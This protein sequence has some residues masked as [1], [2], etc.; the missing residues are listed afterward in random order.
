MQ[1][2]ITCFA[3]LSTTVA[4]LSNGSVI[5]W[6]SNQAGQLGV[7]DDA[8]YMQVARQSPP[9]GSMPQPKLFQLFLAVLT[10]EM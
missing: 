3:W 9:L 6:G 5:S 8:P 7:A 2:L 1:H 4:I 10:E